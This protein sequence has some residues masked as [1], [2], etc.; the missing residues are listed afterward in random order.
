[1]TRVLVV[2]QG[3]REHALAW[4]LNSSPG[5]ESIHVAPGNPGTETIAHNVNVDSADVGALVRAVEDLDIDLTIV[6]PE[7]WL[8]AGL[9]DALHAANRLVVGPTQS[10][11][12][13]ESSKFFARA[14]MSRANVPGPAWAAFDDFGV[15]TDYLNSCAYP[16]VVK[17]DGLAAGKGVAVCEDPVEARR[18]T[19][20]MM[21]EGAF[22]GAGRRVVIEEYLSGKEVSLLAFVDGTRAAALPVAQDHKRVGDG[23]SGPNTGG[24]GAYAPVP[25]LTGAD[26][27][28]L[29][30]LTIDPIL[31]V[32]AQMGCHYR[33]ILFAGLMLTEDGPRVLEYNC[34][35]GDPETQVIVPL[36]AGDLLP[37]LMATAGGSLSGEIPVRDISALGV[38]LASEGYP[39]DFRS[40]RLISGLDALPDNVLAFHAGTARDSDGQL[41]TSGGRVLTIVATGTDVS[42]AAEAAYSAPVE[43]AGMHRRT[44]IGSQAISMP[45]KRTARVEVANDVGGLQRYRLPRDREQTSIDSR[46]LPGIVVMA[47]GGG[48]NLQALIQAS[49]ADDLGAEI[50]LVVSHSREAGSF[51]RARRAGIPAVYV[52]IANRG[53]PA[54]RRAHEEELLA[55]IGPVNPGL[56]VLAG[57]NLVLSS[58]FLDRLTCPIINVHPALLPIEGRPLDIPVL[59]GAHAVRDAL[60]LRLPYTG[61]SIHHV[62][63]DVDSGPVLRREAVSIVPGDTESE[64][65]DRL[66]RVEHRLLIAA[67]REVLAPNT[68]GGMQCSIR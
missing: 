2:G 21:V 18:V 49:A 58:E 47:S 29:V 66:K 11:F 63:A 44:D 37:W 5:V 30:T 56:I 62:I 16:I 36:I 31:E 55:V 8:A 3:A 25:F 45:P 39:G 41:R 38:V 20:A 33:G 23:D 67:V 12:R 61:A 15:A 28:T 34:R 43:F 52:P 19:R 64:L 35:F 10:A 68:V 50:R 26:A 32:M 13:L 65:H 27:Q 51:D 14:V 59:R 9:V 7:G 60:D 46:H 57:W 48:S 53:D 54:A 4:K 22:S 40:G 17:A 42:R 1:M 24:M 6:G